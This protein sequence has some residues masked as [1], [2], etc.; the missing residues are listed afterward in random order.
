MIEAPVMRVL[1]VEDDES[2]RTAVGRLLNAYHFECSAFE[3]AETLLARGAHEGDACVVSD[4]KLPAMSGL[5]LLD[6]LNAQGGWPPLILITAHDRPGLGEEAARRGAAAY[7]TKPFGG[8]TLVEAINAAVKS[9]PC[10]A[11]N[12]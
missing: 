1:L 3:S 8:K 5:E 9:A 12:R 7:L 10:I 11:S 6:E 2:M 4:L